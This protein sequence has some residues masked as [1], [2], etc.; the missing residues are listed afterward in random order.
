MRGIHV[1]PEK[2][3]VHAEGGCTL[4]DIDRATHPYGLATPTGINSTTGIGGLALG[5]GMG[6]LSRRYGLTID[7][8]LSVDM[9]LA[10]GSIVTANADQNADL[11]WAVRGGGGNFGVVTAFLLK[12]HPVSTVIAGPSVWP[13]GMAAEAMR[14]Y[15]DFIS[16][17]PEYLN[18]IFAMFTAPPGPPFPEHLHLKKV[19]GITWCYTGP[20]E[21]AD[22]VFAPVKNFGPPVLYGVKPMPFPT[23]STRLA[24]VLAS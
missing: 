10:D 9:V 11:F 1:D 7:N 16:Q 14:F 19:C 18:G 2:Q 20:E 17:A 22:Q 21:Q 15:R 24:V 8:F 4:G 3:T 5:G 23:L 12:L 6:H 13:I